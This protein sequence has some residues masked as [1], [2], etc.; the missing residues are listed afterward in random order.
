MLT[1]EKMGGGWLAVGYLIREFLYVDAERAKNRFIR[2][3]LYHL[4]N[5]TY[6]YLER[7]DGVD[8]HQYCPLNYMGVARKGSVES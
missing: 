5:V 8:M 4:G 1:I 7:L 3:L 2:I 6:K